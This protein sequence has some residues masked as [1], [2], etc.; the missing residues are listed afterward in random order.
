MIAAGSWRVQ[1]YAQR[2]FLCRCFKKVHRKH[3]YHSLNSNDFPCCCL[4]SPNIDAR[5][6]RTLVPT[7]PTGNSGWIYIFC[8]VWMQRELRNANHKQLF[9]WISISSEASHHLKRFAVHYTYI[10][11]Q[12]CY[13]CY[14]LL[15]ALKW[16]KNRIG[17]FSSL[18]AFK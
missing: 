17:R 3:Y 2:I 11:K 1:K 15:Q 5:C 14:T 16:G 7:L 10:S 12:F 9:A 8:A 4:C 18:A 13:I 6:A